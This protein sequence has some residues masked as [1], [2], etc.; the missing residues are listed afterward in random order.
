MNTCKTCKWWG[1]PKAI[2][3]QECWHPKMEPVISPKDYTDEA[4]A[5][6]GTKIVTGPSFGCIHWEAKE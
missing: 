2:H 6:A 3:P 1:T 5:W 4:T